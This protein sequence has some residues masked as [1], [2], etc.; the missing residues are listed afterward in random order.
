[1]NQ[2]T[3][4]GADITLCIGLEKTGTTT[5]Q[6]LCD[7]QRKALMAQGILYPALLG[8]R[9]HI[10]LAAYAQDDDKTCNV[11]Q[12]ILAKQGVDAPELRRMTERQVET[13]AARAGYSR[14]LLSNEH[15][16]SRITHPGELERLKRLLAPV[17]SRF[18]IAV[19]LRRQD[20]VAESSLSTQM[21]GGRPN[22]EPVLPAGAELPLFYRYYDLLDM[23]EEVFGQ[24]SVHVAIYEDQER[25]D[26]DLVSLFEDAAGIP[27]ALSRPQDAPRRNPALSRDGL[28]I[29]GRINRL[30][31]DD[32]R[33]DDAHRRAIV[34]ELEQS[35]GGGSALVT[36]RQAE[37]FLERCAEQ[38][39]KV[40]ARWLPDRARLF[41]LD[42][43][44]YPDL[45][46]AGGMDEA[47]VQAQ[48]EALL[49]A[50]L[51][52]V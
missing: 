36:R 13:I 45:P 34:S 20:R 46:E 35:H 47:E 48:A 24:G 17:G 52:A 18:R 5:L 22:I 23:Y 39:E 41:D 2:T 44:R 38:N 19:V 29:L 25:E 11:R 6:G 42:L 21:K 4:P 27:G 40:R 49:Q 16:H 50:I 26:T 43:T 12:A 8:R 28:R 7:A 9:N 10:F 33:F 37:T 15:L 51:P 14:L 1:M 3:R 32:A 30:A 31:R